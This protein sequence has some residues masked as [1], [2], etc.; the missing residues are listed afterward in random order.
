MAGEQHLSILWMP[1]LSH[2]SVQVPQ[3]DRIGEELAEALDMWPRSIEVKENS[4]RV[5]FNVVQNLPLYMLAEIQMIS[6]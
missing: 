4:R 6:L 3:S 1:W 5:H 2:G